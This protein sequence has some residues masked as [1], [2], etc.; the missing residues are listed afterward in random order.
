MDIIKSLNRKWIVACSV[1]ALAVCALVPAMAWAVDYPG[2]EEG[3]ITGTTAETQ[4]GLKVDE[5]Q[6]SFTAPTVINFAMNADGTFQVPTEAF[7][8]NNSVMPI[9]VVSYAVTSKS[10]ATGV[11]DVTGQT[12]ADTYQVNVKGLSGD[13]VPFA[14]SSDAA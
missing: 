3:A 9:K 13:P 11:A 4:V 2:Y 14:I 7:I 8:K 1:I 5:S 10:G 6:L 12:G